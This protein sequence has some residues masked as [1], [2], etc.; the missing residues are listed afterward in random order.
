MMRKVVPDHLLFSQKIYSKLSTTHFHQSPLLFCLVYQYFST[1]VASKCTSGEKFQLEVG[2]INGLNDALSVYKTMVKMNPQPCVREFNKLLSHIVKLKEC[3]TALFL[4]KDIRILGIPVSEY[5]MSIA[6]NSYCISNR[7]DY[8]FSLLGWF[9]KLGYVP[10]ATTFS[11][12]LKGLFRGNR[13]D[14]A[15]ELFKKIVSEELCQLNVVVYGTVIDG[16]CKAGN[17]ARAFEL[18]RVMERGSCMPDTYIYSTLIN[19]LCKDKLIDPAVKLFYEMLEKGVVPDVVTFTSLLHGLCSLSRLQEAKILMKDMLGCKV[20]PDLITFNIV[21]DALCKEGLVDDA[22]DVARIMIQNNLVPDIITYNSL[23][24]GYCLQSRLDDA[25]KIFESMAGKSI[26]PDIF[27][28]N[29]LINGYCKGMKIDYALHLFREMP[30]KGLAPDE[31]SCPTSTLVLDELEKKGLDLHINYFN[32]AIDGLC[33]AGKLD[34]A[35]SLFSSLP[36]K[37]L[38]PD[39]VTYGA[40]IKGCCQEGLLEEAKNI[41][42]NMKL[43]SC[44]PNS[45]IYNVIVRGFLAKGEF[46]EAAMFH[47][48]MVDRGLS[49]DYST[50]T[51]LLDLWRTRENNHT[52]HNMIQKFAPEI[53][54]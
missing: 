34:N 54:M 28:Y 26:V 42:M 51:L 1:K 37:G 17:T 18:F 4:F 9:F 21:I 40:M 19:G 23:M 45:L 32:I 38:Q 7:V 15:Q 30:Q 27:S 31:W 48:E 14:E 3:S 47:E 46:G 12:L 16:L 22:E 36:S 25:R 24:D 44:F 6:I 41:L 20:Y 50:L 2:T 53:T 35:R 33:K 8:G 43:K 49:P 13:I 5:T 52:L 11:P 29:I 39:V 10:S